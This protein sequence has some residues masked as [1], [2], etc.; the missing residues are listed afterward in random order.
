LGEKPGAGSDRRRAVA[1][2]ADSE[3]PNQSITPPMGR[4]S[5]STSCGMDLAESLIAGD[6]DRP[7]RRE[8]VVVKHG[9]GRANLY[10]PNIDLA[11]GRRSVNLPHPWF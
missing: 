4:I 10:Y 11:F 1:A 9:N 6:P 2:A 8:G 3:Q 5:V 7:V